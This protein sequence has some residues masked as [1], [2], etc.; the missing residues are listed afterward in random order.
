MSR[1]KKK[2]K[3]NIDYPN[4]GDGMFFFHKLTKHPAKQISHTEKTWTNKRYTHHPNNPKNYVKDEELSTD[5][6][7]IYYHKSTFTDRMYTRGRPYE[8]KKKKR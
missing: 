7:S 2:R 5:D 6:E 4:G 3:Q 8:I 1:R